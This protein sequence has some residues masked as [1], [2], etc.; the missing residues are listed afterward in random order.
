MYDSVS[1]SRRVTSLRGHVSRVNF[2][3]VDCGDIQAQQ[4]LNVNVY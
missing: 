1:V 3:R 2:D 4:T